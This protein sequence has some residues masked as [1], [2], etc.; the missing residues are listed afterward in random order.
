MTGLAAAGLLEAGLGAEI[1]TV[2]LTAVARDL[3][4][5]DYRE[6]KQSGKPVP[7]GMPVILQKPA[8][9]VALNAAIARAAASVEPAAISAARAEEAQPDAPGT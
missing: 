3:I 5:A 8:S 6:R 7:K 9:D 1:P 4:E 2:L